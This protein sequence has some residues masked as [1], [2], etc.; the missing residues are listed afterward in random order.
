MTER[1]A[2]LLR[3]I[4]GLALEIEKES[5]DADFSE[6]KLAQLNI[7]LHQFEFS[8]NEDL[9]RLNLIPDH[10]HPQMNLQH[11]LNF[12]I[13]IERLAGKQLRDDHFLIS[14]QDKTTK[15]SQTRPLFFVLDNLRSAFNVGSIFRL[16]DCVGAQEIYLCGY[17]PTTDN[18]SLIK[19]ALSTLDHVNSKQ[20]SRTSTAL[21]ELRAKGVH[22]VALETTPR[23]QSLFEKPLLG[24]TAFIVGNE[25]F[26]LDPQ[27]LEQADEI[28]SI[29]MY[30]MK[31]S[32]N[33]AN[34][35]S[36]AAFEWSRQN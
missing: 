23:S 7:L 24:P 18:P 16:A 27:I 15:A 11:F 34:A 35:L 20:V 33:V 30:G 26:G 32:L 21:Q 10:L 3:K 19:T 31:N 13:P 36:V 25:R 9:R 14:T 28:R 6:E 1:D 12:M 22:L 29:P 5:S 8:E 2:Q 17:T 4:Q